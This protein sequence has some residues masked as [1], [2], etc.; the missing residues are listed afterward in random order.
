MTLLPEVCS[1]FDSSCMSM[2][3][4]PPPS[5]SN[6]PPSLVQP[7]NPIL[8]H[9]SLLQ[10]GLRVVHWAPGMAGSFLD[11]VF[12]TRRVSQRWRTD[13]WGVEVVSEQQGPLSL[14]PL[15]IPAECGS[16][17]S[18]E[19]CTCV[20]RGFLSSSWTVRGRLSSSSSGGVRN[21]FYLG[22]GSH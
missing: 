22:M 14:F 11:Y 16:E 7:S 10:N 1:A 8:P 9:S 13:L 18:W 19:P 12:L 3:R 21:A 6:F 5:L 2:C 20:H 4:P 15:I 17:Q